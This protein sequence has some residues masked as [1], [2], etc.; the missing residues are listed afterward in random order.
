VLIVPACV[1][2]LVSED[3]RTRLADATSPQR[4]AAR[5]L[6]PDVARLG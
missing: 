5:S 4:F 6:F 2:P 3:K 1:A